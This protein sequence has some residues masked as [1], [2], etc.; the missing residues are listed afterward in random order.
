VNSVKKPRYLLS[1]WWLFVLGLVF[2]LPS[3]FVAKAEV[4]GDQPLVTATFFESDLM[5]S[6]REVALQTGINITADESVKGTI[7]MELRNV[8]LE[9]ALRMMLIG[10]G[11]S[12]RKVDDFYVVGLADTKNPS[13]KDLCD[14]GIY[15]FKNIN[16]ESAKALLPATYENYV[17]IDSGRGLAAITAPPDLL[18]RIMA[19]LEKLDGL[20]RQIKVKALITA[21]RNEVLQEWG[22][23]W[24]QRD[25]RGPSSGVLSYSLDLSN[26]LLNLDAFGD[27]GH[28]ATAIKALEK[29]KKAKIYADPVI[30]VDDGKTGELFV[31]DRRTIILQSEYSSDKIENIEAG[32]ML[33][34]TPRLV[35]NQ[36]ELAITQKV[37]SFTE[38]ARDS[39]SVHSNEFNSS[40]CIPSGGTMMVI[41]LTE[42]QSQ[43]QVSKV[44]I[45]GDIPLIRLFFKQKAN[46]KT[47]SQLLIFITAEVVK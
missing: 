21:V 8:P 31:G 23:N 44:P 6:L 9:K 26:G 36:I 46:L 14:T 18:S 37:S 38:E 19:D 4:G 29:D 39:I 15:C 12:F 1:L 34:V 30:M 10:G 28:V 27:F 3:I 32:T 13:F 16:G 41:G 45:L 25:W 42:N 24:L 17:R 43:N 11:F 40:I 22:I 33:K 20:C 35:G 7:T 5:E 47:D 2:P